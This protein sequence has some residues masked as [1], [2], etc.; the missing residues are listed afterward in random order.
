MQAVILIGIQAS[1]K[2]TFYMERFFRTHVRINLDMLRTRRREGVLLA[3]CLEAGQ[4]FVVDNTNVT[5]RDRARYIA[6]AHEAHFEVVGYYL[7][8]SPAEALARN[9][10]RPDKERVMPVV[11]YGTHHRLEV[12]TLDEGFDR[13]YQVTVAEGRFEIAPWDGAQAQESCE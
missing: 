3:A 9:A 7:V 12:P 13:L 4:R 5:R 2:S 1:G 10:T 8:V 11:I 6:P